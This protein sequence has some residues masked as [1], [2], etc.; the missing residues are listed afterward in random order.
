MANRIAGQSD[1]E[2]PAALLT[3]HEW[4]A[5]ALIDGETGSPTTLHFPA[6]NSECPNCVYDS[7]NRR[8][9]SIYKTGGDMPFENYTTCPMCGGTG[10]LTLPST[11]AI[12]LRV[13]WETKSWID[14]GLTFEVPSGVAMVIGY[15]NDVIKY[16]RAERIQIG[17]YF[18]T[19]ECE[20]VPHG[21]RRDRYF[22]AYIRRI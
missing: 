1:F 4:M 2:I 22:I 11:D 18:C 9:S 21:F 17:N 19:K 15:M 13:Y 10:R 8:S 14:I 12:R 3:T 20:P 16:K 5:D 7:F 6:N